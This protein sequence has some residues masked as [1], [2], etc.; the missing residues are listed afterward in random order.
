[1]N[2][3]SDH[4]GHHHAI[5]A[6]AD[7]GKLR[8]ALGLIVG[9]MVVEVVAGIL[10]DSLALLS[11]AAHM[12]TDAGAVA[13]ALT[14]LGLAA[15]PPSARF[16]FGLG[17]A[18]ILSAQANG[19]TLLVLAG[20]IGFEAVRRLF[21]PPAVE[22]G[23]V[24]A[25]GL[26]GAAV[27]LGAAWALASAERRSLNVEGAR[28]HVLTDLYASLGAALAGAVVVLFG[29]READPVA[30]LLVALLMLRTAWSLLRDSGRV[31]LEGAPAGMDPAAIGDALA[32][33]PGVI[34]VHDLHVWEVTTDFPALAAHVLVAPGDDC[35]RIRRELQELLG[36]R[37][38]IRHTTLQVDHERAE[39]LLDIER[40]P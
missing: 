33:H 40:R 16:T 31:L 6:D 24:I 29:I 17:R 12:L 35:H 39:E 32:R 38:A 28:A 13:L 8:L 3:I 2:S 26:L 20:V 9:F 34:E 1:M 22:G 4:H 15:R 25:V 18:E 7:R 37:F 21:D 36:E 27:N 23:L 19:A 30:A 11:D 14:A 5:S 10:A